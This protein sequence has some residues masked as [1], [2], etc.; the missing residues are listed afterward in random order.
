MLTLKVR[1]T[2][3]LG[4]IMSIS[5]LLMPWLLASPGH[6]QPWYWLCRICRSLSYSKRNFNYLCL[7]SVEKWH[8]I[9][10]YFYVLSEK[11]ARKGLTCVQYRITGTKHFLAQLCSRHSITP[12]EW[13]AIFPTSKL[14]AFYFQYKGTH[15]YHLRYV[16]RKKWYFK[17]WLFET[18]AACFGLAG[19]MFDVQLSCVYLK[20]PEGTIWMVFVAVTFV[21]GME[22]MTVN[23]L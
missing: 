22:I 12:N 11:I 17:V 6:Q 13:H 1:G 23:S 20:R 14:C 7:I 10:I 4:L 5:W 2:I 18:Y 8:R 16:K 9:W 19:R 15:I 21:W 3:Y